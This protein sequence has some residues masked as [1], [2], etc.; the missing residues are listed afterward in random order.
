MAQSFRSCFSVLVGGLLLVPSSLAFKT[1]LSD[2]AVRE[3]YFL[4]Q[5]HDGTYPRLVEKYTKFLQPPKTG[6]YVSSIA[7]Y[8]PFLQIVQYNDQLVANY[9]A[10]QAELDHRKQEEFVIVLIQIQLTNSYPATLIDPAG[11]RMGSSP[12]LIPRAHDFWKEFE[13]QIFDDE[14]LLS[15]SASHSHSNSRCGRAGPCV[16]TGATIELEFPAS[17]FLSDSATIEVTPPEGDLVS[18]HF[19]LSRLR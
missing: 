18:V 10:Q 19:D 4:G 11:R 16:L 2:Q 7:L 15:P 8:T 14:D 3:A 17:A 12:L 9:S 5:R 1:P 13:V 6:P